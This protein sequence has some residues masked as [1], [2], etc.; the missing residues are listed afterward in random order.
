MKKS[1]M[2]LIIIFSIVVLK[3]NVS[4]FVQPLSFES[5]PE[6]K[7]TVLIKHEGT[8]VYKTM[9]MAEFQKTMS[10]WSGDP[11]HTNSDIAVSDRI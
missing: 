11:D 10:L 3:Y 5:V 6:V 2:L 9:K 1:Q 4:A 7:S 8:G